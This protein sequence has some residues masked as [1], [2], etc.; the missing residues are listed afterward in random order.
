[1]AMRIQYL[2]P[3]LTVAILRDRVS[4]G[5]VT[6]NTD[7]QRC[8]NKEFTLKRI[9]LILAT[10]FLLAA[11]N[12]PVNVT[13]SATV[14][15]PSPPTETATPE[16]TSTATPQVLE[17]ATPDP[18]TVVLDFVAAM[19]TAEWSN[20]GEYLP[21]P[22][23]PNDTGA[24]YVQRLDH[25]IISGDIL[26]ESPSL[27][28]IPAYERLSGI[29]GHYP[30]IEV[31]E[32]DIFHAVLACKPSAIACD[33]D[34]SLSYFDTNGTF[35]DLSPDLGPRPIADHD[36]AS[37]VHTE[38]EVDLSSLTGQT[39]EFV[40][41]VRTKG[42]RKLYNPIWISPYIQRDPEAQ[43]P[44]PVVVATATTSSPSTSSGTPG[45]I[46]GM[47][48][49]ASAPP[50]LKDS[51]TGGESPVVVMFFNLDDNTWWWIHSTPTHPYFRM[52]VPPGNYHVV[53]YAKGVGGV[54]YVTG[55]YTG[56]NPSCGKMLKTVSVPPNGSVENIVIAD[57]NWNCGG[58]AYRPDK[59]PSVPLP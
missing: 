39:V 8:G 4:S 24:G 18:S 54:P 13:P 56:S 47:V 23:D 30:A 48:D 15:I 37:G 49:M 16:P 28:T 26:V 11:C 31:W 20:N 58:D 44:A 51:Y 12:A 35:H 45:T 42:D 17:V 33:V 43:Q 25:T 19:C 10:I 52:T 53:A 22:G 59:P 9:L 41:V 27:I 46:S 55:G 2:P 40:L 38:V 21:C 14:T 32:G 3:R 34:F 36:A 50:Y 29:F 57:W 7:R 5:R 6:L 1:M